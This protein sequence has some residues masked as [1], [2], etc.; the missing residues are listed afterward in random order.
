VLTTIVRH[1]WRLLRRD[2]AAWIA[3]AGLALVIGH[4][5]LGRAADVDKQR[6]NIKE[7][8][9]I[10]ERTIRRYQNMARDLE[11]QIEA[12]TYTLGAPPAYG[13]LS[14]RYAAA[15]LPATIP[16]PP[17]PLAVLS[18]GRSD[19]D[20]LA[21]RVDTN[22]PPAPRREPT[23]YPLRLLMGHLDFAF[24][25]LYL[26]PLF[27][28]AL[29]FNLIASERESGTLALLLSQPLTLRRLVLGKILARALVIVGSTLAFS[30][31]ALALSRMS[32][33]APG[34]VA[35]L[36][37][38]LGILM[39]WGG[40]WFG[41]AMT[42]NHRARTSASCAFSLMIGWFV[43]TILVPGAI[44]L[45]AAL[46]FPVPSRTE[47]VNARRAI[48]FEL[49]AEEDG[50]DGR[51]RQ[52]LSDHPEFPSDYAYD[53][54]ARS[55]MDVAQRNVDTANRMRTVNDRFDGQVARQ[56]RLTAYLGLVSPLTLM[57]QLLPEI[58]G[59]GR[60]RYVSF[61]TQI[62]DFQARWRR[63][64]WTKTFLQ[65]PMS[66]ADYDLIPRFTFREP[67][68]NDLLK[69]S[70]VP[71]LILSGQAAIVLWVS[72]RRLGRNWTEAPNP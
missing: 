46:W 66:S 27:I 7:W 21:Y 40:L 38:W 14:P 64:F 34:A 8:P 62:D 69:V 23:D 36:G 33:R 55:W 65:R 39:V 68:P 30:I 42:V 63:L 29:S 52:F 32:L 57:Q 50:A 41:L 35:G 9:A 13:P 24:V 59:T 25:V 18:V 26:Y 72:W 4:A 58:S 17:A 48:A 71:L 5:V 12:G 47:F 31:G 70:L 28:L 45:A 19:L 1:E 60:H 37:L 43:A 67:P 20:T 11:R 44:T 56:R 53:A 61:L 54:P 3:F 22:T 10:N 16:L 2:Y 51:I 15:Y 49:G 6:T